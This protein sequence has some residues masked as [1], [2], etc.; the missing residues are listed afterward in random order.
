MARKRQARRCTAHRTDGQPCRAWAMNG[1][2]VCPAHGGRAPQVQA[3]ARRRLAAEAATRLGLPVETTAADALADG[4]ARANGLVIWLIARLQE[5]DPE[6]LTWGTS[7][8]RIR[9]GA[10][11]RTGQPQLDVLQR[12]RM[13]ELFR[14]WERAE[15]RLTAIAAEMTRLGIEQ[16]RIALAERQGE[17]L[18]M[19]LDGAI[20]DLASDWQLTR[21]QQ[22]QVRPVIARHMR[23]IGSLEDSD[24]T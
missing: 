19:V 9:P 12:E 11:D 21:E 22:Q 18:A 4:L 5:L 15:A 14:A 2:T 3:A 6:A 13:H 1:A 10:T 17:L 23:A 16:H 24:G 20:A 8:R 7:Q